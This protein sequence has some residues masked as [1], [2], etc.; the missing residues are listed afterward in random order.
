MSG[1]RQLTVGPDEADQRLDRWLRRLHPQVNQAP[2]RAHVPQGRHPRRRRPGQA[3]HP[4]R[5]RPDRAPAADRRGRPAAS[6]HRHR[7]LRRRCRDDPRRRALPRRRR[8]RARQAAGPRSPGW[9]RPAAPRRRPRR[10]V[11]VRPAGEAAPRA[12]ARPRHLG[13]PAPRAQ[14]PRGRRPRPRLPGPDDAQGL[15][16]RGRRRAQPQGRHDP[17][18]P[19][20]GAGPWRGRRGREDAGRS[21][22]AG[23][24]DRGRQAR[25]HQLFGDRRRRDPRR[26]GGARAGHRPHPP[27]PRPD[28]GDRPSDRRRRQVRRQRP[29]EPRSRL[30]RP[31]RRP[32]QPQAPPARPLDRAAA[33]DDRRAPVR[34]RAPARAYGPHLGPLRL[35]PRRRRRTI[36]SRTIDEFPPPAC[37]RCRCAPTASSRRPGSATAAAS[38]RPVR[39]TR[40]RLSRPTAR[41]AAA[42]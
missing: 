22:R 8:H 11:A 35:A 40:S 38:S 14:R 26:L 34:H 31:A 29:G 24:R 16:G 3:R 20:Q 1:V 18:R 32:G 6:A 15:L 7:D 13:G 9:L 37:S 17:H 33:S 4:P 10:G 2:H 42:G 27:A 5:S 39:P 21:L 23:G 12:P 28:G 36:R 30:G 25:H 19:R 41:F